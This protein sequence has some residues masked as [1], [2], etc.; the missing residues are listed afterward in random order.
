MRGINKEQGCIV[1]VRPDQYVA[2]VLPLDDFAGVARF[3]DGVLRQ[4]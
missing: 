3:F 1:I 2:D 4:G